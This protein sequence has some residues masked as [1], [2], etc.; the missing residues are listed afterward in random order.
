MILE[1]RKDSRLGRYIWGIIRD[2]KGSRTNR[3][4]QGVRT[5][6]REPNPGVLGNPE[7]KEMR[8]K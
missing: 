8:S 7:V 5:D 1:V 6:G 4:P 2:T 3:I